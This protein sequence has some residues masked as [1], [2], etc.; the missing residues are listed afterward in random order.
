MLKKI[1][2]ITLFSVKFL[3]PAESNPQRQLFEALEKQDIDLVKSALE[4]RAN[5]NANMPI[6]HFDSSRALNYA[7]S[8]TDDLKLVQ[9]LVESKADTDFYFL[10][11]TTPLE[12][13]LKQ[14]KFPM[15]ELLLKLGTDPNKSKIDNIRLYTYPESVFNESKAIA[16]S[17]L[18]K[19][20]FDYTHK[21]NL[22]IHCLQFGPY[23]NGPI[24]ELVLMGQAKKLERHLINCSNLDL[25]KECEM[26]DRNGNTGLMW[27][28]IRKDNYVIDAFLNHG[29]F[30]PSAIK[31][32]LKLAHDLKQNRLAKI[33]QNALDEVGKITVDQRLINYAKYLNVF[34]KHLGI[35]AQ[36]PEIL[37]KYISRFLVNKPF[38]KGN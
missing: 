26:R 32:C 4:N 8:N 11:S 3:L 7:V 25:N 29:Q 9:F 38:H 18:L 5:L 14:R 37:L 16:I 15:A 20:G 6:S 1:L 19:Y 2:V 13:A 33:L 34:Q 35:K 27:A 17:M 21:N 36:L 24:L 12:E 28:I 10:N 23:Y 22:N 30:T 31:E